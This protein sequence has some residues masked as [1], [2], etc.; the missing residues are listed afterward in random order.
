MK[1][2]FPVPAHTEPPPE[3]L[4]PPRGSYIAF[5]LL[6]AVMFN[7]VSLPDLISQV[8]PDFVALIIVYWSLHSPYRLGYIVVW[9]LGLVMDIASGA[10]F[11]QHALAYTLLLYLSTVFQR[12]IIMFPLIYQVFHVGTLLLVIQLVTL[13][14]RL[15]GD[16]DFPGFLYFLPTLIG[17]LLWP[18]V[19]TSLRAPMRQVTDQTP[20]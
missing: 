15:M 13:V 5:T 7:L 20:A 12:R 9:L 8:K 1:F 6:V 19:I 3:L 4:R 2:S 17:A 16:E 10:W 11:G 18:L 14:L